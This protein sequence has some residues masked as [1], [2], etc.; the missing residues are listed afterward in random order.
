MGAN[1]SGAA[2]DQLGTQFG[3]GIKQEILQYMADSGKSISEWLEEE[4]A[5]FILEFIGEKDLERCFGEGN[6]EACLWSVFNIGSLVFAPAKLPK[7][8]A[9]VDKA[10]KGWPAFKQASKKAEDALDYVGDLLEWER[11]CDA[12]P[13]TRFSTARFAITTGDL[14]NGVV[15]ADRAYNDLAG[16]GSVLAQSACGEIVLETF[17]H[18][19]QARNEALNLLGEIDPATRVP[20]VGRLEKATST[21]GKVVGFTTRV[22]GV[23]KQF[24]M[25]WDPSKSAHQC[26]D[27]EG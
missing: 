27:R 9:A 17:D 10:M 2:L 16:G 21:Y 5:D 25:D 4:G 15:E 26:D 24:R 7:L 20:M 8:I 3:E 12:V 13:G 6:I 11:K 22:D 1:F 18:Y 14:G 19:E 23:Y